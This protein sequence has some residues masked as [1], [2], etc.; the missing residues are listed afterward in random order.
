MSVRPDCYSGIIGL[1]RESCPCLGTAPD[2]A[3][4]SESG[5]YIAELEGLNLQQVKASSEQCSAFWDMMRKARDAAEAQT[6]ADL[7]MEI[8]KLV[9]DRKKPIRSVIGDDNNSRKTVD[10]SRGFHGMTVQFAHMVGG[11]AT[12]R[13][14]GGKFNFTGPLDVYVYD[15]YLGTPIAGYS[16]SAVAG[17]TTWTDIDPLELDMDAR[18]YDNT[19]YWFIFQHS[20]SAYNTQIHCGCGGGSWKPN[21]NSQVP[22]YE[23][24]VQRQGWGWTWWAMASGTYGTD[25]STREDWTTSNETQG[26]LLDFQFTCNAQTTICNDGFDPN[27]PIQVARAYARL[28]LAGYKLLTMVK[29]SSNPSFWTNLN[30][31]GIEALRKEYFEQYKNHIGWYDADTKTVHGYLLNVF[32]EKENINRYGDCFT[33]RDPWGMKTSRIRA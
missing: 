5:L 14:I 13:R 24:N 23:S 15:R 25:L 27:D 17:S 1:A 20:G 26:L 19:R 8:R 10:I 4:D 3:D 9:N 33:C 16:I 28:Y 2:D 21:W 22:Y 18:G 7:L 32:T 12:L 11:T 31:D 6:D 29:M 30:G